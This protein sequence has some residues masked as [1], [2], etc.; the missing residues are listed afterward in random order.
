MK[1]INN[2]NFYLLAVNL[3]PITEINKD[4]IKRLGDIVFEFLTAQKWLKSLRDGDLGIDA[5]VCRA[6]IDDL[7][8]QIS[9]FVPGGSQKPDF[10]REIDY[11][12]DGIY[13][14]VNGVH[15]LE[16]VLS[17]ELQACDTYYVS[18]KGIYRTAQLIDQAENVFSEGIR[19]KIPE[20]AIG[21]IRQAGRCLAFECPTA[22][23]FHVLR[24]VEAVLRDYYQ[25][26]V[27]EAPTPKMSNW[28]AYITNLTKRGAEKK[29]TG[30]LDQIRDL[31]RNPV[32]HPE[33]NL[34]SDEATTL[35][36]IAHSAIVAM[37]LDMQKRNTPANE[38]LPGFGIGGLLSRP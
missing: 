17:A 21:D 13:R 8:K 3:H 11:Y 1:R 4:S 10:D 14:I 37:I 24:A 36:G 25:V 12:R 29:V 16:T 23:G 20:Q 32:L 27:G 26:V 5:G 30:I 38:N 31:Y 33:Q 2:Y 28:G 15:D 18:E 6:P 9:A 7:I 34:T 22:A 19:G 35:F